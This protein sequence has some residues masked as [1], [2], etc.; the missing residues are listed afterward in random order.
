M[1]YR[2]MESLLGRLLLAGERLPCRQPRIW[3]RCSWV[4]CVYVSA[5]CISVVGEA[6]ERTAARL[7]PHRQVL[8]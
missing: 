5:M 1:D 7:S 2:Y 8:H 3:Y 4:S 6:A